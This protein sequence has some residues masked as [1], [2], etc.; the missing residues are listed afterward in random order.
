[1]V[2]WY[3]TSH[4]SHMDF[5][6]TDMKL[7]PRSDTT[8]LGKSTRVKIPRRALVTESAVTVRRGIASG[9]LVAWSTKTRMNLFPRAV[10]GSRGPTCHAAGRTL[11]RDSPLH[12]AGMPPQFAAVRDLMCGASRPPQNHAA[13]PCSASHGILERPSYLPGARGSCVP[14]Y[15]SHWGPCSRPSFS[16]NTLERVLSYL[17]IMAPFP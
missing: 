14:P 8:S 5:M 1:M 17:T 15:F 16:Q 9:Y 6:Y 12:L 7:V 13:L 10:F 4:S 2:N 11:T 3:V